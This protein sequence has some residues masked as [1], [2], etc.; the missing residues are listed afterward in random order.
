MSVPA[1]FSLK[2]PAKINLWLKILGRRDDGFHAVETR[3]APLEL[4]DELTLQTV[5]DAPD[6]TVHFTCDDPTVPGDESNLVVKAL[7]ALEPLTGSL[8]ALRLHL[9]KSIPHGAGLGG[10][11]SDAAAALRLVRHAFRPDLPDLALQE[12][13]ASVGS[14]VPF[15]LYGEVAD[16]T[17]RGET[18]Q[19][20]PDFTETPPVLLVKLPFGIPTPWAYRQWKGAV[21]VPGLPYAPQTTP[22]GILEN[23][24][25]RPVFEKYQVLGHLKALLQQTPGV[26]AAL[27]SGSGSTVFAVLEESADREAIANAVAEEIGSEAGWWWTRLAPGRRPIQSSPAAPSA[28]ARNVA[29]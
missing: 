25:E 14:D 15:F 6:G 11:S 2:A 7:R 29:L 13:A 26:K 3:M 23:D 20:V 10:G 17:G 8:P 4:A 1:A 16:A 18:I 22:W 27:M 24:L 19:P 5:P 28:A 12:A 9:S 21:E